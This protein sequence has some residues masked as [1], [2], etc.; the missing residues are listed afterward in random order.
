MKLM[1]ELMSNPIKQICREASCLNALAAD[2]SGAAAVT[3]ALALSAVLGLAGLGTEVAAWYTAR[4]TMQGA[5]DAAAYTAMTAKSAGAGS[6]VRAA[7]TNAAADA[8]PSAT[9]R[10]MTRC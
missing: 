6:S 10:F 8:A 4:Q 5:A 1:S 7:P 2:C 3:L 9:R